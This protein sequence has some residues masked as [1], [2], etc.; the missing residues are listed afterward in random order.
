[1]FLNRDIP[2]LF[3]TPSMAN[4]RRAI[5]VSLATILLGVTL[6]LASELWR[7]F[8]YFELTVLLIAIHGL[9]ALLTSNANLLFIFRYFLVW[10]LIFGTAV[11]WAIYHGDVLMAPFGVE[12]Q[13]FDNTR[14]LVFSGLLSLCGSLA[15]WHIANLRFRQFNFPDV[16]VAKKLRRRLL[17]GGTALAMGFGLLYL[18]FFGE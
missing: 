16:I 3:G 1:M 11:V 17:I 9:V 18:Y 6:Y 10:I 4:S 7:S 5:V 15:G 14:I 12:Y 13:T 2:L 8:P